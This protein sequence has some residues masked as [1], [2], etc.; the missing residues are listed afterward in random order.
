LPYDDSWFTRAKRIALVQG[1]EE[2]GLYY[3]WFS[4][5]IYINAE[6]VYYI[7]TY[8]PGF[9][10]GLKMLTLHKKHGS[11]GRT[12]IYLEDKNEYLVGDSDYMKMFSSDK[13]TREEAES[14]AYNFFRELDKYGLMY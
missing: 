14:L 6:R 12:L 9:K 11:L 1:R 7:I 10:S 13:I 4:K 8:W 3:I 2:A 5:T